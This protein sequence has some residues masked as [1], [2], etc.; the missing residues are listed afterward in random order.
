MFV[1]CIFLYIIHIY[2]CCF[3][4]NR[5]KS[6]LTVNYQSLLMN[7]VSTMTFEQGVAVCPVRN[8]E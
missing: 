4:N 8:L 3:P 2:L 7:F 1:F 6:L 5:K